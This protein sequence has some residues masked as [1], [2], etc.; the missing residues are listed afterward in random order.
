M[1]QLY[2][3][4]VQIKLSDRIVSGG[5]KRDVLS[6]SSPCFSGKGEERELS[7]Y[8][9]YTKTLNYWIYKERIQA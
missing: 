9:A 5:I 1:S 2:N 8:I 7:R 3:T 6:N 4:E